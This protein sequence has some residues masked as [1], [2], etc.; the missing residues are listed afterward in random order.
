MNEHHISDSDYAARQR[1]WKVK[2]QINAPLA[3]PGQIR[4][5][6]CPYCESLN[7]EGQN[8]CC[9][10][11]RKAVITILMGQRQEIIES[12]TEGRYGSN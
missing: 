7:V 9:E 4:T 1:L 3:L 5:I 10:L 11:L 12:A 2:Q 8:L 6:T